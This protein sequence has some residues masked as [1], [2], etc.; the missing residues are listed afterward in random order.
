MPEEKPALNSL[1]NP[2]NK[3][4]K[5]DLT[6]LTPEYVENINLGTKGVDTKSFSKEDLGGQDIESFRKE[7]NTGTSILNKQILT[8]QQYFND[9]KEKNATIKNDINAYNQSTMDKIGNGVV[10]F[11]GRVYTS[12]VG[13][14]V[15]TLYGLYAW[16]RDGEFK[17]FYDNEFQRSLDG[18][19]D[20]LAEEFKHYYTST[21]DD[22]EVSN[23]IFD[24]VFD[25]LGFATGAVLSS[26]IGGGATSAIQKSF[27]LTSLMKSSAVKALKE[28]AKSTTVTQQAI[29]TSNALNKLQV[30]TGI[31]KNLPKSMVALTTGAVY[32]SGVEAR[33]GFSETRELLISAYKQTHEGREPSGDE[34]MEINKLAGETANGIFAAN[35]AVVGGGNILQFGKHIGL[36]F[37]D[38]SKLFKPSVAKQI[39]NEA[40]EKMFITTGGAFGK[41]IRGSKAFVKNPIVESQEEMMQ[42]VITGTGTDY[43]LTKYNNEGKADIGDLLDSS[44]KAFKKTY[45]SKEGWEEGLIGAIVGST[46]VI[47]PSRTVQSDGSKKLSILKGGIYESV[48]DYRTDEKKRTEIINNLNEKGSVTSLKEGITHHIRDSRLEKIKDNAIDTGQEMHYKNAQDDQFHSFVTSRLEAGMIESVYDELASLKSS[49]LEDVKRTLGIPEGVEF[50][51]EH[52]NKQIQSFE[53]RAKSIEQSSKFVDKVYRGN[54]P[55][56]RE[57]LIYN[58]SMINRVDERLTNITNYMQE[59]SGLSIDL[60]FKDEN[61]KPLSKEELLKGISP[62]NAIHI[63]EL[64]KLYNDYHVLESRSESLLN[65]LQDLLDPKEISKSE[66]KLKERVNKIVKEEELKQAKKDKAKKQEE[67]EQKAEKLKKDKAAKIKEKEVITNLFKSLNESDINDGEPIQM[68]PEDIATVVKNINNLNSKEEFDKFIKQL[69]GNLKSLP[70]PIQEAIIKKAEKYA[71]ELV[72]LSKQDIDPLNASGTVKQDDV[73]KQDIINKINESEDITPEPIDISKF[74]EEATIEEENSNAGQTTTGIENEEVREDGKEIYSI[75]GRLLNVDN[76]LATSTILFDETNKGITHLEKVNE[77][78]NL[79]V[80]SSEILQEGDTVSIHLYQG[81]TLETFNSNGTSKPEKD[82]K[83]NEVGTINQIMEIRDSNNILIG[84]IHDDSYITDKRVY[85]TLTIDGKTVDNLELNREAL[86]KVRTKIFEHINK[87]GQPY[88]TTIK[89]KNIGSPMLTAR[90]NKSIAEVIE[91]DKRP[92]I[93]TITDKGLFV[94]GNPISDTNLSGLVYDSFTDEFYQK[95]K[96]ANMIAIPGANG[97]YLLRFV[98]NPKLVDKPHIKKLI[99]DTLLAFINQDTKFLNSLNIENTPEAIQSYLNNFIF[100]TNTKESNNRLSLYFDEN[101]QPLVRFRDIEGSATVLRLDI[102]DKL[103][104]L[105]QLEQR[106]DAF[107]IAVN[108]SKQTEDASFVSVTK[109]GNREKIKYSEFIKQNLNTNL[110][111]T[112]IRGGKERTY[113]ANPLIS[114]DFNVSTQI[115]VKVETIEKPIDDVSNQ[116]SQVKTDEITTKPKKEKPASLKNSPLGK[117]IVDKKSVSLQQKRKNTSVKEAEERKDEC[118]NN[119]E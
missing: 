25:G 69:N 113:V 18:V 83:I 95:Y 49:S 80:L 87:T 85:P 89:G 9:L 51:E 48:K 105:K 2:I 104:N 79:D 36:D 61:G 45:N 56:I 13:S 52:K 11:G 93:V 58:Q 65:E 55:L 66:E 100:A 86:K 22:W 17:S 92:Q 50:T 76:T 6:K 119:P 107:Q 28:T 101:N 72:E 24:K 99:K 12:V 32:E 106:L 111:S 38:L 110:M 96:G 108:L 63:G 26:L 84:Y 30:V 54:D 44:I 115:G 40:G 37:K 33:H 5:F 67:V 88:T 43:A 94:G 41:V 74:E 77:K 7:T 70:K 62:K 117:T 53:R 57:A 103:T 47:A 109:E 20:Y 90:F 21:K 19:N 82:W 59:L 116:P 64:T 71:N 1:V 8:D 91:N 16:G 46:G 78:A 23:F 97:K 75:D 68:S 10:K 4:V 31:S 29:N 60:Q 102:N 27:K 3:N 112:L 118:K 15:G 81:D 42:S 34:L 39:T 35:M 14:T 73:T 114:L 98:R